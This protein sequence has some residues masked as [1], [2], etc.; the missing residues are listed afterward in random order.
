M[1]HHSPRRKGQRRGA[2]AVLT[3]LMMTFLVGMVAFAVDYGYLVK[4]RTDMQ[5][6]ADA[7][8]LAAVQDLVPSTN[9]MQ[10]PEPDQIDG[11]CVCPKELE[12]YFLPN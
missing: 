4:V 9:G 5:R 11:A 6:A 10:D 2:I 7:A 8:A 1:L 3:A 12:E